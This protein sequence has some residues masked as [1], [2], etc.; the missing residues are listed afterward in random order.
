MPELTAGPSRVPLPILVPLGDE[1][2][3]TPGLV[4]APLPVEILVLPGFVC[5]ASASDGAPRPRPRASAAESFMV[6]R[7][8]DM[9][10]VL[11]LKSVRSA[12]ST[13]GPE[14]SKHSPRSSSGQVDRV[15]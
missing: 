8:G 4:P 10:A 5:C 14:P 9:D 7:G 2:G 3:E 1:P 15:A 12:A 13:D 11:G 6:G